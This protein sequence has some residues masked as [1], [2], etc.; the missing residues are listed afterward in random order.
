L[1]LGG[2]IQAIHNRDTVGIRFLG[3]SDR[4]LQQ[5]AELIAE[6]EQLQL[7]ANEAGAPNATT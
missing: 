2:V 3:M 6:I 1:R 5:V 7:E 4:K